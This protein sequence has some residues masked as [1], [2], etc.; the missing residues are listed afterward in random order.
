M[1]NLSNYELLG[2]E[3]IDSSWRNIE[4]SNY[5]LEFLEILL[6]FFF[7]LSFFGFE[8]F[9]KC[10]KKSLKHVCNNEPTVQGRMSENEGG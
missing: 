9:S 5:L 2:E 6:E 10:P 7:C 1:P 8:F 3:N 4:F